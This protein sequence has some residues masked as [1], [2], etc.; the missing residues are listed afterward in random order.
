M[1]VLLETLVMNMQN[2]QWIELID[3]QKDV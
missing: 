2:K 3:G 1:N